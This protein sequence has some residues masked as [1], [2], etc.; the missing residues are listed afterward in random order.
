MK[1]N[2]DLKWKIIGIVLLSALAYI[3]WLAV[4]FF[5]E[6]LVQVD[7]KISASIIGG[8]FTLFAG[9]AV[10]VFTQRQIKEREIAEAHREKKV[11][12]Y[13]GFLETVEKILQGKNK[14]TKIKGISDQQLID[15]LIKF[16]TNILLWGSPKVLKAQAEFEAQSRVNGNIFLSIDNLYRAIREDI[17]LSNRG[18]PPLALVK[19]YL[20]DPEELENLIESSNKSLNSQ[21]KPAGTPKSGAR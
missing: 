3:S 13:K 1:K 18:L 9:L 19:M 21:A 7:T 11:E 14:R 16:K 2:P 10:V 15:Y 12:I 17:G 6:V 8:M 20:S 4:S 5:I